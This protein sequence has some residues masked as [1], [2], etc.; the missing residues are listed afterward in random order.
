MYYEYRTRLLHA[1][2]ETITG[3]D[4]VTSLL[5]TFFFRLPLPAF[6]AAT[7]D[8]IDCQTRGVA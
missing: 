6:V 4:A 2:N 7:A 1:I 3:I 5:Y 8:S